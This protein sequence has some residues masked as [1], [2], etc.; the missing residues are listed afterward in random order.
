MDEPALR[1]IAKY[2]A[3]PNYGQWCAR[4][5]CLHHAV[6]HKDTEAACE[7]PGCPCLRFIRRDSIEQKSA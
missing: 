1:R 2:R 5:S 7:Y 6:T 3:H 4:E